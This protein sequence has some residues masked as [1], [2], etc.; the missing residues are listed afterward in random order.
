MASIGKPE[1]FSPDTP[2]LSSEA[3]EKAINEQIDSYPKV[4]RKM[5]DPEIL[6]QKYGNLSFMLLEKPVRFKGKPIYGYVKLRGNY[7][8]EQDCK[9][10]AK[11]IIEEVDSK[12]QIKIAHVGQWVP[13]TEFN[14][15]VKDITDVGFSESAKN[16][17]AENIQGEARKQKDKEAK[18][19]LREIEEAKRQLIEED[20]I[21]ENPESLEFYTMKRVTYGKLVE[22]IDIQERKLAEIKTSLIENT[23]ILKRLDQEN[24][25]YK[26]KWLDEYNQKREKVSIGHYHPPESEQ[27]QY[28]SFD[29]KELEKEYPEISKLVDKKSKDF[30]KSKSGTK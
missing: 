15:V 17:G 26:D 21:Y 19:H 28:D 10:A 3:L 9:T 11:K 14:G 24:S 30:G 4:V 20:D 25:S 1:W 7:S 2:S 29:L 23:I 22:A 5:D 8:N 16:Q 13:I 18:R 6:G 12:F 27:A